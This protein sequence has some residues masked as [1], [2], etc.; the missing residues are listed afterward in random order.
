M[1]DHIVK[2]VVGL[3]NAQ[4][5]TIVM[6]IPSAKKIY[7]MTESDTGILTGGFGLIFYSP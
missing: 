7:E 5:P 2:L 6:R 4:P 3:A 1:N